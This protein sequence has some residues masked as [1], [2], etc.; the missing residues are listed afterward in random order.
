LTTVRIPAAMAG[1]AAIEM[2]LDVVRGRD[3]GL[4]TPRELSAE[5]IVR[6]STGPAHVAP[7]TGQ[8]PAP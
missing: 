3:A 4:R 6:S 7:D 8:D 5:L 1:T 2:L